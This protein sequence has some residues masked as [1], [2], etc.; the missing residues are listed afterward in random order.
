M[1]LSEI[2]TTRPYRIAYVITREE[3]DILNSQAHGIAFR[4]G[5][6]DVTGLEG[7]YIKIDDTNLERKT[8]RYSKDESP[9]EPKLQFDLNAV[10]ALRNIIKRDEKVE[11]Y[12]NKPLNGKNTTT[13]NKI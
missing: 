3:A 7:W 12:F 1:L 2:A 6:S 11:I 5:G 9:H 4:V 8:V 10:Q 13:I